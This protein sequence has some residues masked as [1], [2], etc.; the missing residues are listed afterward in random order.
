[1]EN[2]TVPYGKLINTGWLGHYS[3]NQCKGFRV[4]MVAG[5]QKHLG[6]PGGQ[7]HLGLPAA[8]QREQPRVLSDHSKRVLRHLSLACG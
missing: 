7:K 4:W 5:G 6:L 1:M 3:C 8:E 2:E